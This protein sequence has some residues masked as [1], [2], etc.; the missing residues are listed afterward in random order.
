MFLN[1]SFKS[2]VFSIFLTVGREGRGLT[3]FQQEPVAQRWGHNQEG[4]ILGGDFL[5]LI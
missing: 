1:A 3:N 4:L 2:L 5:P